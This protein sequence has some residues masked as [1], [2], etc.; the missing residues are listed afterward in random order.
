MIAVSKKRSLSLGLVLLV[1]MLLSVCHGAIATES[2]RAE[3][4]P[5]TVV[6]LPGFV[7]QFQSERSSVADL[8]QVEC[9]STY[10]GKSVDL[11]APALTKR[12]KVYW[13]HGH[14]A[15]AVTETSLKGAKLDGDGN[16]EVALVAG[17][18][19]AAGEVTMHAEL[20]EAPYT[21]VSA[22][23]VV[24]G[25]KEKKAGMEVVGASDE[26]LQVEDS[27]DGSGFAIAQVAMSPSYYEDEVEIAAGGLYASC[28]TTPKLV[29]FTEGAKHQKV[30]ATESV[31]LKLDADGN[32]FTVI[33]PESGCAAGASEV[34]A[35]LLVSPYTKYIR[36]FELESAHELF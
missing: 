31:K 27:T 34:E 23:F 20:E 19:C 32:A 25:A 26:P 12:C 15:V 10:S 24:K 36:S 28:K 4:S 1:G 13:I 29:W 2:A 18:N 35:H 8:V 21:N 9:K 33:D 17:P 11:T 3:E 14:S 30:E 7:E 5:C 6:S 16:L 22:P